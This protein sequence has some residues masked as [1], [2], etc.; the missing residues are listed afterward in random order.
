VRR[1]AIS[2]LVA[3]AAVLGGVAVP[4][5]A[6]AQPTTAVRPATALTPQAAVVDGLDGGPLISCALTTD[7]LGVDG[8]S[9]VTTGGATVPNRVARWNGS[10]WKGVGVTLPKG[11]RSDDLLGVSCRG[12]RSCL[13]VGDYYTSTSAQADNHPLA[14]SYN[15]TSLRPT[16]PVPL[17]KGTTAALLAGVSCATATHCVAFGV[18]D[19]NTK[20]F[21]DFG[22][23]N[24]L[25]TWNG[26]K[27]TLHT[28]STA[29]G[30]ILEFS[31]ISCPTSAFCVVAGTR[32]G[33][34]INESSPPPLYLASWNG[35]KLT[36]MKPAA[37]GGSPVFV[38]FYGV[39]CATPSNCAVIG[40]GSGT[41]ATSLSSFA[42]IWNGGTWRLATVAWPKGTAESVLL[43]VSCYA[44][45]SC[46]A[47]GL[48]AAKST[49]TQFDTA[50]VSFNGTVGTLQATPA[51]PKGLSSVFGSL[52]CL[53][54]GSCV[55]IGAMGKSNAKSATLT[56]GVWNG[57]AWKLDPGL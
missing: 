39:S 27:W 8:S 47:V 5:A 50:A 16:P 40:V 57:K 6:M 13:V 30:V 7:C 54:W 4:A 11:T 36:T 12:A 43:S 56:T 34:G 9:S 10:S 25:E 26:A 21:G 44:A 35:V 31:G 49:S 55:A 45:R 37:P 19:G 42:E 3:L 18:A 51:P 53:P 38:E 15:G 23:L 33:A 2:G 29:A 22:S 24:I 32:E 14:L 46:E 48:T 52:S 20:E 41:S 28:V 17:P 1:I